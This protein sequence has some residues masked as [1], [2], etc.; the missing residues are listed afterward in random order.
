[1]LS[2]FIKQLRNKESFTQD[3]LA[4]KLG[5]SRPTYLQI[6][7]GKRDVTVTEA[8]K[9]ADIFGISVEDLI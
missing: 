6:E 2:E 5:I 8:K 7:Q 1:M 9:F 4:S 3:F